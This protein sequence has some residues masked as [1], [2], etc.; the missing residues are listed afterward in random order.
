MEGEKWRRGRLPDSPCGD[1]KPATSNPFSQGGAPSGL[2]LQPYW[3]H[4]LA[5]K[6]PPLVAGGEKE[7]GLPGGSIR[8]KRVEN[9]SSPVP[10]L[11]NRASMRGRRGPRAAPSLLRK[12][13]KRPPVPR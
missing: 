11:R 8:A 7:K 5:F 1:D 9:R 3:T 13:A 10:M 12:R 4:A 2:C 6:R